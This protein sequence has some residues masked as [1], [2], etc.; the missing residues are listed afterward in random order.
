MNA[1]KILNTQKINLTLNDVCEYLDAI[2]KSESII[3][4][5]VFIYSDMLISLDIFGKQFRSENKP[6]EWYFAIRENGT[7]AGESQ[8]YVMNRLSDLGEAHIAFKVERTDDTYTLT[9]RR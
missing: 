2:A 7:E 1:K 4:N 9:I 3:C 8:E 6:R 5:S